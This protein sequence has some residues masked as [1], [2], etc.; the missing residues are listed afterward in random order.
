MYLEGDGHDIKEGDTFVAGDPY[1][2]HKH[3]GEWHQLKYKVTEGDLVL[4]LSAHYFSLSQDFTV[5]TY[6]PESFSS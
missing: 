3:G 2:I 4:V 6:F 1:L 5:S